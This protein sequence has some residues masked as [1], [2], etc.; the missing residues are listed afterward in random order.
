[1]IIKLKN[2]R[3]EPKGAVEPVKKKTISWAISLSTAIFLDLFLQFSKI[4]NQWR[5]QKT[6]FTLF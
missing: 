2:L 6:K 3:P 4:L 5:N 1:M